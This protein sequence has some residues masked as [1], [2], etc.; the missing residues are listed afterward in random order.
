MAHNASISPD[1]YIIKNPR[2]DQNLSPSRNLA[3]VPKIQGMGSL[4]LCGSLGLK[5]AHK[6][7]K[8]LTDKMS[9]LQRNSV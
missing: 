2:G 3:A 9:P 6:F 7:S 8:V 4:R 5:L 1:L